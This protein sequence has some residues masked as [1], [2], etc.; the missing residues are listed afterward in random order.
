M[1]RVVTRRGMTILAALCSIAALA[2]EAPAA[3]MPNPAT[4]IVLERAGGFAGTMDS[5]VVDRSTAG[6][7]RPRRMAGSTGF[8]RLRT[9]YQPGNPC[10]DRYSYRL[11][12]TYRGGY[13]KTISTVQGAPA[14]GILWEVITEVERVGA[15]SPRTA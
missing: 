15:R 7:Q 4:G 9:S 10:C 3:A 2:P 5:F 11:T 8:R 14:P 1:R 13:H 6:G 12:V